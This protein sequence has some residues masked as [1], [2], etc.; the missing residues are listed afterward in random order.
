M[1]RVLIAFLVITASAAPNFLVTTGA[2][3][4]PGSLRQ[5]ILDLNQATGCSERDP[6]RITFPPLERFDTPHLRIDLQSP[7]PSVRGEN[8]RIGPGEPGNH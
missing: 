4:G 1:H 2:D 8:I 6:C 3:S 5:A 7:L